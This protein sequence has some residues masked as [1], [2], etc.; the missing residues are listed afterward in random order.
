MTQR[1]FFGLE[2]ISGRGVRA[3]EIARLPFA[4][5][6]CD[7][8]VRF[9]QIKDKSTGKWLVHLR[10]WI[11]FSELFI[12][13][14]RHRNMPTPKQ[15]ACFDR[16]EAEPQQTY[17]GLEIHHQHYVLPKDI[18][19]LPFYSFWRA[20]AESKL[21]DPKIAEATLINRD[22]WAAFSTEFIRTGPQM[23]S[24][25]ANTR[26]WNRAVIHAEDK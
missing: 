6:W 4:A 14:G 8:A 23:L 10:D 2:I 13:T 21:A 22:D 9:S 1:T 5:F 11:L 20:Y 19:D 25:N 17:F 7:S 15:V 24:A 16:D 12:A 18:E 26:L 3:A